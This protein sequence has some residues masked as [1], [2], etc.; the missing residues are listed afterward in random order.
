MLAGDIGTGKTTLIKR[1]VKLDDVAAIFVTIN[2]PDLD[3]LD[4]F[5]ILASEFQMER[6]FSGKDEFLAAFKHFLL[7]AFSSYK[8][9]LIIIDEAQRLN[10]AIL[11]EIVGL[12]NLQMAGRKLLKVFFVGQL[13]FNAMLMREENREVLQNIVA[14]YYLEPL[15]ELETESYIGHRLEVAGARQQIFTLEAIKEIFTLSK[16]YPRL[17]NIICDTALLCGYGFGLQSIDGGIIQQ[18]RRDLPGEVDHAAALEKEKLVAGVESTIEERQHQA[19]KAAPRNYR[20]FLV[21]AAA[22]VIVGLVLMV[23]LR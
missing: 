20:D 15:S 19:P 2:D 11:L 13:E 4:F 16:G 3:A 21:L 6:R 17:I 8:K 23:V 14:H 7:N 12:S 18:C 1:L 22:I 10:H 5:N 9:V